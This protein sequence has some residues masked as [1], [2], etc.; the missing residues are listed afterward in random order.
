MAKPYLL[1][2]SPA[3]ARLQAHRIS[4]DDLGHRDPFC[5]QKYH[6]L[7]VHNRGLYRRKTQ[8]P[9]DPKDDHRSNLER[10]HACRFE[11]RPLGVPFWRRPEVQGLLPGQPGSSHPRPRGPLPWRDGIGLPAPPCGATAGSRLGKGEAR[12]FRP[13]SKFPKGGSL[14]PEARGP[15]IEG[16]FLLATVS[17][18]KSNNSPR[19]PKEEAMRP[20]AAPRPGRHAAWPGEDG[21]GHVGSVEHRP[22]DSMRKPG[23]SFRRRDPGP[24]VRAN[25]P[26]ARDR[27]SRIIPYE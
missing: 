3:P 21:L 5:G 13:R 18:Q 15:R 17:R 22:A 1:L 14:R 11:K 12:A 27:G 7:Y 2:V 19:I 24:S 26:R 10:R 20:R 4:G 25:V 23:G 16:L 6:P 8:G 9:G